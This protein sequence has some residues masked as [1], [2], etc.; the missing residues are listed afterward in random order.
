MRGFL[1]GWAGLMVIV[2]CVNQTF[3]IF[4]R[5]RSY[6]ET[7]VLTVAVGVWVIAYALLRWLPSER[8]DLH[9]D[10]DHTHDAHTVRLS[11]YPRR[12]TP[13]EDA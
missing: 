10:L 1:R 5:P 8:G 12:P 3:V 6:V 4:T 9:I 2:T 7:A 11:T 13:S